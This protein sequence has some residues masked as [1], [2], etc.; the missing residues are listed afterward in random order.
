MDQL[1]VMIATTIIEYPAPVLVVK[2]KLSTEI[3]WMCENE[4]ARAFNAETI[5][6]L[7]RDPLTISDSHMRVTTMA[8]LSFKWLLLISQ[9]PTGMDLI[10]LYWH[11]K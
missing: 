6:I 10:T 5:N 7:R 9:S 4:Y 11:I 3:C 2:V 1:N 8:L